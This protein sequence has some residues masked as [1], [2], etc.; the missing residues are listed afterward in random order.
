[1]YVLKHIKTGKVAL[2]AAQRKF[3]ASYSVLGNLTLAAEAA[4]VSRT[5]HYQW[6]DEE[7][8][9]AAFLE[10]QEHSID[11]LV[12]EA[13]RRGCEGWEEPV[14]YQ[15]GLCY[16]R[17]KDGKRS[18]KPLVIRKYDS[19]LLMF[20]IKQARPEFRD[21]WKGEIKHS[22]AIS[23]GPDLSRLTDEQLDQLEALAK[24]AQSSS[25]EFLSV[26]G[27]SSE[28]SRTVPDGD[29]D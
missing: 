25:S 11:L 4:R 16:E 28:D 13:R 6:M 17:T 3:L 20:L 27:S 19:N 22:G 26:S 18:P 10:A 1:M 9:R 15:G 12:G 2:R 24:L 14:V 23:R 5:S 21:T 7:E 8:Y 29:G